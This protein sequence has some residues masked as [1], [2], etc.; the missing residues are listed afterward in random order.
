MKATAVE[1]QPNRIDNIKQ[2]AT[3]L[4]VDHLVVVESNI[5]DAIYEL[6][7]PDCI[8]IGGGLSEE[9]LNL[10]WM[11]ISDGTRVVANGVTIETDRLL[12]SIQPRFGG[13][14]QRLEISNLQGI[15][16]M[17][18]WKASFPITQWIVKKGYS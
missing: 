9:L 5:I 12:T 15:G 1:K 3:T 10:L 14:I 2:N 13:S 8:F 18:G 11:Y 7:K 16:T 17:H 4:G 6:E